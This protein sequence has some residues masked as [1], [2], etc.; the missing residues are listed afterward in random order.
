M[1]SL[2]VSPGGL[3]VSAPETKLSDLHKWGITLKDA[4]VQIS[5][6]F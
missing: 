6:V 2:S 1:A 4:L 3:I 5:V